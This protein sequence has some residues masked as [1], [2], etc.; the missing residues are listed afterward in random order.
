MTPGGGFGV[1]ERFKQNGILGYLLAG[2]LLGPHA[3]DLIPNHEAV[4]HA[5]PQFFSS[6]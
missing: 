1:F 3:L 2:A 6:R 5:N 4:P